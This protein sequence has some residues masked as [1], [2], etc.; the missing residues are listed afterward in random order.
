MYF[1]DR[2]IINHWQLKSSHIRS[3]PDRIYTNETRLHGFYLNQINNSIHKT[4]LNSFFPVKT[5]AKGDCFYY[6]ISI[7]LIGSGCLSAATRFA[8]VAKI[9]EYQVP[10]KARV[11]CRFDESIETIYSREYAFKLKGFAFSAGVARSLFKNNINEIRF[12]KHLIDANLD[13]TAKS[14]LFY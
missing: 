14:M 2:M 1:G 9:I 10:L 4:V 12:P 5:E 3:F 8:T 13:S 7:A 11:M 6:A